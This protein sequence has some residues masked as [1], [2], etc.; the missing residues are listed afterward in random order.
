MWFESIVRLSQ[1]LSLMVCGFQCPHW[2]L[3]AGP[4][5][6]QSFHHPTLLSGIPLISTKAVSNPSTFCPHCAPIFLFVSI[7]ILQPGPTPTFSTSQPALLLHLTSDSHMALIH[8]APLHSGDAECHLKSRFPG[9]A[10]FKCLSQP[11]CVTIKRV[12]V[13]LN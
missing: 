5:H 10:P 6:P 7:H 13:D 2:P 12:P 1:S 3:E 11:S 8:Q 9:P 4:L